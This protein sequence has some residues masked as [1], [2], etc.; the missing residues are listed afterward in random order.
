M[1]SPDNL[2]IFTGN[3]NPELAEN[4]AAELKVPLGRVGVTKF[5]DG[6]I[7]VKINESARGLDVFLLQPTCSPVNDSIMELLIMIDAFRRASASRITVVLPYYGY[8]RQDK[9][10]KPREPVTARLIANLITNAGANRVLT[11]DLHA[12][13]IQGFFD[14]P[15]DHLYAGP[16]IAEHLL[17]RGIHDGGT[18]VVSPDVGGVA[19]AR[20]LA[21]H[22]G[23]P[24]AIIAKRRPEA[25]KV[26]I[27]EIIGDVDGK[28]CVMIDDMIDT[29]GSIVMGAEALVERGASEVHACAT[30]GV[31]SGNAIERVENSVL[32]SLLVTDTVPLSKEKQH[33]KIEVISVAP[34][35]ADAIW[36]IHGDE[37][38]SE[39]FE[40][41]ASH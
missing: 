17:K 4:I 11:V 25:N 7:C 12:G 24:I 29:G 34:L 5:S 41:Y 14:I 1:R 20:A 26:E 28:I 36:R 9:K 22:L 18:V 2:R 32:K 35:L 21:E 39:L 19:R 16:L 27:M 8:A 3:A 38:V 13:Q 33:R 15:T 40:H 23:T 10:V 30:H 31:L 6:E 37:S